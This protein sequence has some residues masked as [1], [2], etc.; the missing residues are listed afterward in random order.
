MVRAL[1][2]VPVML[3]LGLQT[4]FADAR[5]SVLTDVMRL[6][7]VTRIL[8][9]E[10]IEYAR[11]LN[12]EMLGGQGGV[13]WEAQV[14]AIYDPDRMAEAVRTELESALQGEML[15]QVIAFYASDLGGRIVSLENSARV[16][17]Q[18]ADIEEAARARHAQLD[19]TDDARFDLISRYI[20]AG[21]MISRNVTSAMNSNLYFLR[22]LVD[23]KAME[24]NEEDMLADVS[25]DME[26]IR[27]DTISWLFGYLLL[28]YHPLDQGELE[29]YI[30]FARTEA[31][32]ALNRALFDGFGKAYDDISYALGRAVAL[33][34]AAQDI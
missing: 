12:D 10:G 8:S 16:A 4:A 2:L 5:M 24:M 31:G 23:G 13:G 22:G 17:M 6:A 32:V 33:N 29:R 7:E 20:D 11:D 28:A 18:D 27:Q 1:C 26:E 25:G 30:D 21:D 3:V 19:G 34:M 9:T 15:E 14:R